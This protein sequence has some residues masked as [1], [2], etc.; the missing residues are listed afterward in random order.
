M[1]GVVLRFGFLLA[2]MFLFSVVVFPFGVFAVSEDDVELAIAKAMDRIGV[3]YQAVADADEAG[4]NITGLL[5]V[6]NEAGGLLSRAN[7]AYKEKNFTRAHYFA[8]KSQEKLD[9]FVVEADGLKE[10]ALQMRYWDFMVNFVGSIVGTVVVVCGGF[11]VWFLLKKKY[12]EAG[13]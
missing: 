11:V 10:T 7:L 1:R 12:A 9:G 6:L 3:C 4:A 5:A 2:L 13:R 8:V